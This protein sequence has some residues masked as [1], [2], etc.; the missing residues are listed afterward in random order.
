MV[1]E[2]ERGRRLFQALWAAFAVQVAG[3][4]LDLQWHRAHPEFETGSD[5]IQAH[6]LVWLGTILVLIV[7]GIALRQE[8]QGDPGYIVAFGANLL[9][10][11]VAV[12]HFF[13][14]L[15]HQ[16]VDWAHAGLAIT[17]IAALVG[18]LMV[19]WSRFQRRSN[20]R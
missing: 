3:R 14:H 16:E 20:P 1:E 2:N 11:V 5:Q 12:I 19:T 13:Q 10:A 17:N 8:A 7:A 6:W 9:Y 4:V 15:D 18:V